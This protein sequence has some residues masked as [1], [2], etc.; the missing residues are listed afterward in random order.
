MPKTTPT[1]TLVLPCAAQ[2][3]T[4]A[5]TRPKFLL[6]TPTGE[7]LLQRAAATVPGAA[8]GR[9]IVTILRETEERYYCVEAVRRAFGDHAECV[10]LEA[11]T[12][13]PAHTVRETIARAG[14]TGPLCIKDSDSFFRL[15]PMP[16]GSFIAV[17]DVRQMSALSAP[18]RKSYVRLNEQGMVSDIQ[19]KNVSSNFISVGL[20]GFAAAEAFAQRF[21][22][23]SASVGH[24][25][26]FVSHVAG[27][28]IFGG[29]L[30]M[31]C[32]AEDLVDI[33]TLAD[34]NNYRANYSTI[35][36]DVDGVVFR[37]QSKF[38]DPVWGS[39]VEPI[40]ENVAHIRALQASGAQLVFMTA[41]PEAY[42]AGTLQALEAQ[43]L[44]V[45]ALVMG[46]NHATRVLVNDFAQSN[47]YPSAV[48]VNVS[49]DLPGLPT[50][51]LPDLIRQ[52]RSL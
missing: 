42:R 43:G 9:I 20:Y 48:A 36:L 18:G 12:G 2:L 34:W 35:V 29:E 52:N 21:D 17:A 51:L 30:I 5:P 38:F 3:E 46:C 26:L 1:W 50:L 11:P 49:R 32:F 33:G 24:K 39:P 28:A 7:L 23:L 8:V 4:D 27:N 31:P 15:A 19:E 45:H 6:T 13:G 25:R 40:A 44:R 22:A 37:N 14:I 16:T 47:A 10:V 41:R